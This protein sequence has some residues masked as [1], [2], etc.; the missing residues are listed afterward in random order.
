LTVIRG[1]HPETGPAEGPEVIVPVVRAKVM[2]P[3]VF[4]R[5]VGENG[6]YGVIRLTEF[7]EATEEDF[8]R[9]VKTL[10]DAGVK[11]LILDLRGNGGGV[12]PTAVAIVDR[13][14]DRGVVVRMEGR[15]A[16]ATRIYEAKKE[17]T[18]PDTL[19]LIVLVN[20]SSAS[21]SEVVAGA[22][23]DHRRALLVGERTYGKF[24]VQ[25]ITDIP[26]HDAALQLTTSR[27]YLPSGRSYQRPPRHLPGSSRAPRTS[28]KK[29]GWGILP[30][31]VVP[32]DD[33]QR[34]KIEKAFT[35]QEAEP[36][37]EA[38]PFDDVRAD[39]IDPQ[40]ARAIDLLQGQMVLQKIRDT[41]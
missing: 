33:A 28:K 5:R 10:R 34:T 13:F 29:G 30:D 32:V 1:S 25:Q 37:G 15:G 8:N 31:V 4:W 2:P 22:L 24:L 40:L 14:V 12:L 21:A 38:P 6:R 20:G 23:Q 36:W 19:P 41:K 16:Q 9:A 27:Y 3:S 35:N 17:G 18:L 39:W 11:G 7:A 26:M